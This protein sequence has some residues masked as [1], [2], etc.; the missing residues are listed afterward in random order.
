MLQRPLHSAVLHVKR[1]SGL[2]CEPARPTPTHPPTSSPHTLCRHPRPMVCSSASSARACTAAW[3]CTSALSGGPRGPAGLLCA[4]L[5]ACSRPLQQQPGPSLVQLSAHH[6]ASASAPF[7][8]LHPPAHLPTHHLGRSTTL[9]TWTDE[10]LRV[11]A[12]GG[13][14]RAR[15]FFKQHGWDETGSDKIEAK[16][17]GF[18]GRGGFK[19]Q[20]S[21]RLHGA[22]ILHDR[23]RRV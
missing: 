14:Q 6:L 20:A 11:M 22:D 13:N 23:R 7:D 5:G 9:D 10:Q 4:T 1:R 16:V 15:T 2:T 21:G 8:F 3:A 18:G 12:V 19:V 17:G